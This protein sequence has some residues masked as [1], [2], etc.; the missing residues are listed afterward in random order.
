MCNN[1]FEFLHT[2]SEKINT[3]PA[4]TTDLRTSTV[5]F[6]KKRKTHPL[7]VYFSWHITLFSLYVKSPF[8]YILSL[9][10]SYRFPQAIHNIVLF[11]VTNNSCCLK[12]LSMFNSTLSIMYMN[13]YH[14]RLSF[15]LHAS[16]KDDFMVQWHSLWSIPTL[17]LEWQTKL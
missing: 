11:C 16:A 7:S 1:T 17:N 9:S 2:K 12:P 14:S 13:V 3:K 4:I 10:Q 8:Y 15:N 6:S 5:V